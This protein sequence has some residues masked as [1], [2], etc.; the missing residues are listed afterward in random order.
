M[1]D[2]G[3]APCLFGLLPALRGS[4]TT[5]VGAGKEARA[6]LQP[7]WEASRRTDKRVARARSRGHRWR[8]D[9]RENRERMSL[10]G[11]PVVAVHFAQLQRAVAE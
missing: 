10:I 11:T 8:R 3:S 5:R 7:A 2:H 1:H 4:L 9:I 6:L